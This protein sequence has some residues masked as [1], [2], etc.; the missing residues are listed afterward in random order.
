MYVTLKGNKSWEKRK[1][2]L[3]QQGGGTTVGQSK[4]EKVAASIKGHQELIERRH[5]A[6]GQGA[7]ALLDCK[8]QK[9]RR[10][11]PTKADTEVQWELP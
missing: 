11:D 10:S 4:Q 6:G 5:R 2:K 9:V 3:G 8:G 7:G 1:S